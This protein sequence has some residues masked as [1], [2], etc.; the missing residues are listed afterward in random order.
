LKIATGWHQ[1]RRCLSWLEQWKRRK[2]NSNN[3]L[4]FWAISWKKW[5]TGH[6]LQISNLMCPLQFFMPLFIDLWQE[7]VILLMHWVINF[8]W[9]K[10][11][12]TTGL[13]V[14]K[15]FPILGNLLL[16]DPV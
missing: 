5:S 16:N 12:A 14:M 1:S 15:K 8:C 13:L 9:S 3:P 6:L 11:K 10:K 7:V 4:Q 2:V